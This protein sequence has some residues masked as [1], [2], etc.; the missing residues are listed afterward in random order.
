MLPALF[1]LFVYSY[2][3]KEMFFNKIH[4]LI[5]KIKNFIKNPFY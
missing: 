5:K 2:I 3:E 1:L 4:K